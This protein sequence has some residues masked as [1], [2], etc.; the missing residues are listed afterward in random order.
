MISCDQNFIGIKIGDVNLS[1][2]PSNAT[3]AL[4]NRTS[5]DINLIVGSA[6]VVGN[7]NFDIDITV[8]QFNEIT[9]GQFSVNWNTGLANFVSLKNANTT[10]GW[11]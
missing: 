11:T 1:N 10:L 9:T 6:N 7:Q 8:R 4:Q 3:D 5:A 2:N